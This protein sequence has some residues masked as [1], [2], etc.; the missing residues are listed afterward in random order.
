MYVN[1]ENNY[2]HKISTCYSRK[3]G[4]ILWWYNLKHMRWW[5]HQLK[6][7]ITLNFKEIELITRERA[8]EGF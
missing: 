4:C 3:Y 5:L 6:H 1:A 2:L 7:T 8:E